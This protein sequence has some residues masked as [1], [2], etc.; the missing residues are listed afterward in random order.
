MTTNT[1][2]LTPV[3]PGCLHGGYHQPGDCPEA[4]LLAAA[5]PSK[6]DPEL[7]AKHEAYQELARRL[8]TGPALRAV[9]DQLR[10][11]DRGVTFEASTN[12]IDRWLDVTVNGHKYRL[13]LIEA[14]P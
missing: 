4:N 2:T 7:S 9:N 6:H 8:D 13:V 12:T 1:A 5:Q 14:K 10:G 3:L 11:I